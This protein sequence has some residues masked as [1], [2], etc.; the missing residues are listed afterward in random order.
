MSLS[1]ASLS[2]PSVFA[3]SVV[4]VVVPELVDAAA[5]LASSV[6]SG[7]AAVGTSVSGGSAGTTTKTTESANTLGS[8]KDAQLKLMEI[9][10]I[11]DQQ[12]EMFSLVSNLLRTGHDSR[13]AVIQ[14]LR[15]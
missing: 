8:D 5:G 2:D 9:Q 11:M 12:K 14:N 4:F 3:D 1:C 7:E 6:G 10:R 13:M 15:A